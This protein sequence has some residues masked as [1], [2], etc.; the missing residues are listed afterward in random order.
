MQSRYIFY[1][2]LGTIQTNFTLHASNNFQ[3][4]LSATTLSYSLIRLTRCKVREEKDLLYMAAAKKNNEILQNCGF[5]F[6]RWC[7]CFTISDDI[8]NNIFIYFH[9]LVYYFLLHPRDWSTRRM[10]KHA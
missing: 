4:I 5:Q 3:N 8:F 10:G 2:F 6:H 1:Q 9:I 7:N